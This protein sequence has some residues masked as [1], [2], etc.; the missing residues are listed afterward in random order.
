MTY[1]IIAIAMSD[2]QKA[3]RLSDIAPALDAA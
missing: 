1:E 3:V 2:R